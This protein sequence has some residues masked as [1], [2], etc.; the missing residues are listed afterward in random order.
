MLHQVAERP[1]SAIGAILFNRTIPVAVLLV[2]LSGAAGCGA[3]GSSSKT[4]HLQGTVTVDGQPLPADALAIISFKPTQP[5]QAKS[6]GGQILAGKYDC[7]E[8]PLGKVKVY[9]SIQQ[10]TGKTI[11]DRAGRT[12]PEMKNL[13]APKSATGFELDVTD[14]NAQQDFDMESA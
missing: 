2:A 7:A 13:I 10:P 9:I 3:G 14:D 4:A 8:V 1:R 6:T 11:S 12:S 5:G